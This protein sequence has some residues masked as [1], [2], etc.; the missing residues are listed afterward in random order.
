MLYYEYYDSRQ[1]ARDG[2]RY[3][4]NAVF[5]TARVDD[6]D[7]VKDLESMGV[8]YAGQYESPWFKTFFSHG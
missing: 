5:T 3:D 7:M 6:P 2:T 1:A 8:K 4:K